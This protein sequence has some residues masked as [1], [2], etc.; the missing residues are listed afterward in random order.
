MHSSFTWAPL[1]RALR[2]A[3]L[4]LFGASALALAADEPATGPA[5][6]APGN[7]TE[8]IVAPQIT[9]DVAANSSGVLTPVLRD[10]PDAEGRLSIY[11]DMGEDRA[12]DGPNALERAKLQMAR[13]A[14][15]ASRAAGT[16]MMSAA[17]GP[18]IEIDREA[19]MA[20]K[21]RRLAEYE[22]SAPQ[23]NAA[24]GVGQSAPGIVEVGSGELNEIERAKLA[25][26]EPA[27]QSGAAAQEQEPAQREADAPSQSGKGGSR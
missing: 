26:E 24:D 8:S 20:E 18:V 10:L 4:L 12:Y 14:V 5:G 13:E 3:A 25:G 7:E 9:D 1:G 16:L 27:V 19:A 15:E 2:L 22:S 23:P 6:P 21:M 11:T 17:Q